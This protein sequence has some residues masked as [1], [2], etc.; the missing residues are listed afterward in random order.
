MHYV[1]PVI[2]DIF[3][4]PQPEDRSKY[5]RLDQNENPDGIPEWLFEDVMKHINPTFLSIYPEESKLTAKYGE[6]LGLQPENITLT[7]GSVVGMGYVI[8]VFGEPGKKM[9]CVTPSFGM[10]KVYAEMIGMLPEIVHYES[11]YTFNTNVLLDAIDKNTG[12]ISLVNP[13]MPIG[14][15]Y[16][17]EDILAIVKKAYSYNALVIIDEAYYYF[18]EKTAIGLLKEYSNIVILRT[19]SKMLSIPSLRLGMIIASKENIQYIN[20]YKPHYTVNAIALAFGE[21][22]VDNHARLIAELKQKFLTGKKYLINEL[23]TH[24]YSFLPTQGCF[25]CIFPKH[26]SVEYITEKLRKRG[27]LVLAGRGDA[28]GLLRVTIWGQNYMKI[29]MDNFLELDQ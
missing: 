3:R 5:V 19:F 2:K 27:I 16:T 8:K 11:D 18:Y 9:L 29:F 7:D 22:I 17:D 20:N 10:Y 15:A 1:N 28:E 14:N 6:L 26:N 24:S 13:N 21:A 25:V 4:I 23:K 12:I